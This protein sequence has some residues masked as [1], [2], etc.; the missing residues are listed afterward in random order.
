M[1]TAEVNWHWSLFSLAGERIIR[2]ESLIVDIDLEGADLS[3]LL[4]SSGL[5]PGQDVYMVGGGTCENPDGSAGD[6]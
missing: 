5:W 2:L 6:G 3:P 4:Q 1:S